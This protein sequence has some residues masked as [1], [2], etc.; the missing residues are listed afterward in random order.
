MFEMII[1][2]N[3]LYYNGKTDSILGCEGMTLSEARLI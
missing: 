1:Q 2:F 3:N